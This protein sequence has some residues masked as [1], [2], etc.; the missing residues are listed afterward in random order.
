MSSQSF[1][2]PIGQ[3]G[4]I[5]GV[6]PA[7]VVYAMDIPESPVEAL[8]WVK[9]VEGGLPELSFYSGDV[10][11]HFGAGS[12][13]VYVLRDPSLSVSIT[14]DDNKKHYLLTAD[15]SVTVTLPAAVFTAASP[16]ILFF[17]QFGE[18]TVSVVGA[19]GVTVRVPEGYSAQ[20]VSRYGT[21]G[22]ELVGDNEW[23]LV[24]G[25]V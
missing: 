4:Y 24:G 23:L 11:V 2:F 7:K 22:A 18:G 17:S 9:P 12:N 15:T 16:R 1:N 10:W 5:P 8:W 20:I 6:V 13:A 21:I 25:L 19:S 14:T 3:F